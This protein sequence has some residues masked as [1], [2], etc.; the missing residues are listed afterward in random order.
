MIT[1]REYG[2]TELAMLYFPHIESESAWRKLKNW[3][4]GYPALERELSKAGYEKRQRCFTPY[5]VQI[6][7]DYIGLPKECI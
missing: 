2:R 6:I 4:E 3:I 5:Q 7:V 1:I